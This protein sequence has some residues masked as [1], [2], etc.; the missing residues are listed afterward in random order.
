MLGV[1]FKP[2]E[3]D[4]YRACPFS[5]EV[6]CEKSASFRLHVADIPFIFFSSSVC[7]LVTLIQ[8]AFVIRNVGF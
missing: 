7:N 6:G 5:G 2:H 1:G 8:N 3:A 4:K